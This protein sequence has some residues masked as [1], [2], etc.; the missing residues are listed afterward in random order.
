LALPF[1]QWQAELLHES[2]F[3]SNRDFSIAGEVNPNLEILSRKCKPIAF[4]LPL[5]LAGSER[6]FGYDAVSKRGQIRYGEPVW[7]IHR[8]LPFPPERIVGYDT[9][10][11]HDASQML[12]A[13]FAAQSDRFDGIKQRFRDVAA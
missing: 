5:V 6:I 1:H 10:V 9:F 3:V 12:Y 2:G 4:N 11:T 13:S 8:C 7:P